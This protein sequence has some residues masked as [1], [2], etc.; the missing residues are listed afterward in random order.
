MAGRTIVAVAGSAPYSAK[1]A[2]GVLP[3]GSDWTLEAKENRMPV[4]YMSRYKGGGFAEVV[5]LVKEWKAILLEKCGAQTVKL[6]R[7]HT[8]PFIG[9]WLFVVSFPD[10][11][12]YAKCQD[13]L[14]ALGRD[15][16]EFQKL[17][18][19]S[20]KMQQIEDKTLFVEIDI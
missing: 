14:G 15:D 3:G 18:E 10:W 6:N 11:T 19:R 12:A 17:A 9:E 20:S 13:A 16:A 1:A 4:T 5:A 7:F 2:P 8:G